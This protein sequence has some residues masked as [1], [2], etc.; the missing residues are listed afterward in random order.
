MNETHD[1]NNLSKEQR[2]G[3]VRVEY[4]RL[5]AERKHDTDEYSTLALETYMLFTW[6][7]AG[8]QGMMKRL[9]EFDLRNFRW[10]TAGLTTPSVPSGQNRGW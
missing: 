4:S 1:Y 7:E 6:R 10:E 8:W 5:I 9:L 3:L 2:K